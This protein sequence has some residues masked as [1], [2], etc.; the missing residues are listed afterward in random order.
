MSGRRAENFRGVGDWK[1]TQRCIKKGGVDALYKRLA[2]GEKKTNPDNCYREKDH[3][4]QRF[5]GSHKCPD[6]GEGYIG[7]RPNS[8]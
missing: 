5:K 6:C 8:L 2:K 4:A 7:K 3:Y 1:L